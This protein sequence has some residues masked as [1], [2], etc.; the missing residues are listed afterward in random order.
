MIMRDNTC[1]Y[2]KIS[3]PLPTPLCFPENKTLLPSGVQRRS[4]ETHPKDLVHGDKGTH[5]SV[6]IPKVEGFLSVSLSKPGT[7]KRTTLRGPSNPQEAPKWVG[8][9]LLSFETSPTKGH[10]LKKQMKRRSSSTPTKKTVPL[11][12]IWLSRLLLVSFSSFRPVPERHDLQ[13]VL[14]LGRGQQPRQAEVRDLQSAVLDHQD[15]LGL[16]VPMNHLPGVSI[17]QWVAPNG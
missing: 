1:D 14:P 6:S 15:V 8:F 13:G 10:Q 16:E 12:S 2:A 4:K 5:P 17:H 7:P 3:N 9:L 11:R